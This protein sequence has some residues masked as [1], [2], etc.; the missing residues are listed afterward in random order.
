[1]IRQ[2]VY[3]GK[4]TEVAGEKKK[5]KIGAIKSNLLGFHYTLNGIFP[6]IL[7]IISLWI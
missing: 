4:Q 5:E 2:T 6:P 3:K 7:L 1:M